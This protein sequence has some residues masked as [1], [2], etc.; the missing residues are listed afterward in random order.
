MGYQQAKQS[1]SRWSI[2]LDSAWVAAL[3][4]EGRRRL[5][6][7]LPLLCETAAGESDPDRG[8]AQ[9]VSLSSRRSVAAVLYLVFYKRTRGRWEHLVS[10]V[11]ASDLGR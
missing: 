7:F 5:E 1:W 9:A 4:P 8:A 2:F 10:L 3:Q 6:A 11:A